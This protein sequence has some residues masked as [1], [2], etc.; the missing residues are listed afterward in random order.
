VESESGIYCG[1][2]TSL[3]FILISSGASMQAATMR[4]GAR[5]LVEWRQSWDGTTSAEG[6]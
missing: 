6:R 4:S 5:G 3:T 1:H 2:D